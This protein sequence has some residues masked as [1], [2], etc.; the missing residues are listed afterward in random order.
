MYTYIYT[1]THIYTHI[2]TYTHTHMYIYILEK[3][4]HLKYPTI[5]ENIENILILKNEKQL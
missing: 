3:E 2:Y 5:F 4:I 1:H